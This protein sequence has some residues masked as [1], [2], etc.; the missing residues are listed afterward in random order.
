MQLCLS[1]NNA[2]RGQLS[3]IMGHGG[4]TWHDQCRLISTLQHVYLKHQSGFQHT[5]CVS[6]LRIIRDLCQSPDPPCP[7]SINPICV[8]FVMHNRKWNRGTTW[9]FLTGYKYFTRWVFIIHYRSFC[10][11]SPKCLF[12]WFQDGS[13]ADN[14]TILSR[15]SVLIIHEPNM[16]YVLSNIRH[17]NLTNNSINFPSTIIISHQIDDTW[18][19]WHTLAKIFIFNIEWIWI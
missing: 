6:V 19:T 4:H 2:T 5:P 17:F 9:I 7:M 1:L 12:T 8:I 15:T 11:G 14:S 10:F 13:K 16:C 18:L 3:P